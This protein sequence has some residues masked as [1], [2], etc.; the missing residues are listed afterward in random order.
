MFSNMKKYFLL[1]AICI[2]FLFIL[3]YLQTYRIKAQE[4]SSPALTVYFFSIGQGDSSLI[5]TPE[6]KWILVDGG[7]DSES[8]VSA[9]HPILP[10]FAGKIDLMVL[11]HPHKDHI[12]GLIKVLDTYA[13][14]SILMY[15]V[16]ENDLQ[17]QFIAKSMEKG[18]PIISADPLIDLQIDAVTYVDV[19]SPL[20]NADSEEK[21]INN[22]SVMFMLKSGAHTF[23]YTG[24]A[25][26]E[27]ER[28][29][30]LSQSYLDADILKGGH[31][32]SKTSSSIPFLDA[33]SPDL[34]VYMN[35][36]DNSFGHPDTQ[37]LEHL[38]EKHIPY[39]NTSLNGTIVVTCPLKEQKCTSTSERSL[40]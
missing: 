8:A 9:M 27:Q 4:T 39:F 26:E 28:Q 19:L 7:P 18:I 21:N 29:L 22:L 2:C 5:H 37:T 31:H 24:D 15:G 40:H 20:E 16:S 35:G 25:E 23:L 1:P 11:S 3:S 36:L 10:F 30:L 12:A 6:N 38:D 14:G 34:V 33:V 32:G 17:E 13:V